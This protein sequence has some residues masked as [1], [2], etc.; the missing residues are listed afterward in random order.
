MSDGADSPDGMALWARARLSL[1]LLAV[2]PIGLGGLWLRARSGPVRDALLAELGTIRLPRRRIHPAI[3]DSQLFG[4]ID[5]SATLATGHVVLDKGV[6]SD[7]AAWV[8]TM[9]ERCPPGLPARIG[10]ALDR[11]GGC[12]IALDEGVEPEETLPP[13]LVERLGLFVTLDDLALADISLPGP[14][15]EDIAAAQNRLPDVTLPPEAA[16]ELTVIAARLGIQSLRAPLFAMAAA[17]AHAALF[18]RMTATAEDLTRAADLIYAHRATILPQPEA[19]EASEPPPPPQEAEADQGEDDGTPDLPPEDLVLE[20]VR[21]ALPAGLLETLAAGR[22]RSRSR[23]SGAGQGAKRHGNRRGRPLPSRPGHPDGRARIDLVAT[24]RAAAPWQP[25]RRAAS[26]RN[27]LLHILPSDI[28][29]RRFE[30]KSDR[31]LVFAV[32]ASGSAAM[33]RLAEAKG[34]VE[35]LLAEAYARRDHVALIAFRGTEAD[36]L[37]PPTRSLV[38]TK[39]RLSALPGGGGTPLAAGL[40]AALETAGHARTHG[41][42]PSVVLL[43]DG[44]ANIALDGAA[45]RAQAAEDAT[46]IAGALKTHGVPALVVDTGNR[47]QSALRALSDTL[48]GTYIPL[49]RADAERLS[50]AVS[51]ALD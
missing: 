34:A 31:L 5:L 15:P 7:P 12:L 10:A 43:T 23:S 42:T 6:L 49:P 22:E 17:R 26:P 18:G 21:A 39:R 3:T 46:R 19:E 25:L 36:L 51:A 8:L 9:A 11:K 13:A 27:H 16:D 45:D 29:L 1:A 37:L 32:D 2:D 41:L 14:T 28:R 40:Q 50:S 20:A 30:D 44:R 24:L 35:I 38:Q 4:G 47:P 48:E 33:A